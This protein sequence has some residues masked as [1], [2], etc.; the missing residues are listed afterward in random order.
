VPVLLSLG[1]L[2]YPLRFLAMTELLKWLAS[3]TP[4]QVGQSVAAATLAFFSFML[5]RIPMAKLK[6]FLRKKEELEALG[7][8]EKDEKHA[9]ELWKRDAEI[10]KLRREL[11]RVEHQRDLLES[12]CA[13]LEE[14]I[15]Q[16]RVERATG[17]HKAL[18]PA[19]PDVTHQLQSERPPSS[20]RKLPPLPTG[21]KPTRP[22]D[23]P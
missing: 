18:P 19:I 20:A 13:V 16:L 11:D 23:Q 21:V 4:E 17:K 6:I 7:D 14:R 10:L 12:H 22:K 8:R 15:A 1:S 2:A 9:E 3:L 5:P